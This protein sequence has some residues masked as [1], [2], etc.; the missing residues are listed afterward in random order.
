MLG[1]KNT[2]IVIIN[3]IALRFPHE[4]VLI[5]KESAFYSDTFYTSLNT[6][7]RFENCPTLIVATVRR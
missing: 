2:Q 1:I 3:T 6:V 4:Y 5:C 7:D